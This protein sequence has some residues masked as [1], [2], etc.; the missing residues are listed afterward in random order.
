MASKLSSEQ[1]FK[2]VFDDATDS[3]R[4]VLVD[5]S[6]E[7]SSADGDSIIAH[8]GIEPRVLYDYIGYD[9]AT[10][11]TVIK[12]YRTGGAAGT[13]VGTVTEIYDVSVP[14]KLVSQTRT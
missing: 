8:D 5:A 12:T 10:P 7:I 1:I 6:I 13:V 2:L 9:Y 3:F 4:M 11:N 14:P